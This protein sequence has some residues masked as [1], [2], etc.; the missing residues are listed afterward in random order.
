MISPSR[1]DWELHRKG[2]VDQ[3]RHMEK[4]RETIKENLPDFSQLPRR[5]SSAATAR[6]PAG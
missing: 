3:A 1:G 2:P 5:F 6:D 4:I